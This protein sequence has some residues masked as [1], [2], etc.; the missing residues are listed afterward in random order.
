MF[1]WL[2]GAARREFF[3]IQQH[4]QPLVAAALAHGVKAAKERVEIEEL[5]VAQQTHAAR[6]AVP[7]IAVRRRGD[8]K[9]RRADDV[10]LVVEEIVEDVKLR[11]RRQGA[12]ID[13]V[14][15]VVKK[16]AHG[17]V[18]A[19]ADGLAQN[20]GTVHRRDAGVE[21]QAQAT[22]RVVARSIVRVGVVA[23]P[24]PRLVAMQQ[25][26]RVVD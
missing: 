16:P 10:K 26:C 3:H 11:A 19:R 23:T 2:V 15:T 22:R 17:V 12:D 25:C 1:I 6:E 5:L 13:E 18:G 14:P 20:P 4:A 24:E 8:E 21:Q 7:F 9:Q